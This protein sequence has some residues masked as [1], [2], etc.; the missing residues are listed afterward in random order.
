MCR[1]L[2]HCQ[3]LEHMASAVL[4][5]GASGRLGRQIFECL[6]ADGFKAVSIRSAPL[7]KL[8]GEEAI[9]RY[10]REM[11]ESDNPVANEDHV[12]KLLLAHRP[13]MASVSEAVDAELRMT[14]DLVWGLSEICSE[15]RVIVLGSITGQRV[16]PDS[17]E[18]YHYCKDL[19]KSIV[20]QSVTVPNVFMNLIELSWFNKY[21]PSMADN[22]YSERVESVRSVMPTRHVVTVA[23]ITEIAVR[24]LG[25]L[26]PPRGQI[27]TYDDGYSLIQQ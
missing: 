7:L 21:P 20:R 22:L 19:Q 27:V 25:A 15:V 11:L 17:A 16:D 4:M 10:L 9:A 3:F 23:E 6:L 2:H 18:A 12:V 1:S 5:T 13:R 8:Q 14:R 26:R 24:I